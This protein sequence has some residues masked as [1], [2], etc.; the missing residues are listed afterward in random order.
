MYFWK[1]TPIQFNKHIS[2]YNK[3]INDKSALYD[4]IAYS[5]GVYVT[6]GFHDPENYP[7]EPFSQKVETENEVMTDDDMEMIARRNTIMLGGQVA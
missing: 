3:R 5:I 2:A 1:L 4:E 7:T 6:K